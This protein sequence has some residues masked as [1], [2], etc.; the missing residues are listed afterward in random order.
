MNELNN[1]ATSVGNYNNISTALTSN[2]SVVNI[3][4]GLTL[5]K[6]ADKTNWSGG[7]LKYTITVNN[8]TDKTYE[9]PVIT[10][11]ID[12]DLVEFINGSVIINGI[13]ASTSQYRYNNDTHTLSV[14]LDDV[15]PSSISTLTFL[16]KKKDQ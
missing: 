3:I 9:K 4:E 11:V 1:T 15:T 10:D 5:I 13:E 16:V 2:T 6:E 8:Q 14:D 7:N 12:T